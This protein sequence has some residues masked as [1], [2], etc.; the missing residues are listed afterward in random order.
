MDT[1]IWLFLV[2]QAGPAN[3]LTN[4]WLPTILAIVAVGG[5]IWGATRGRDEASSRLYGDAMKMVA[6]L[7]EKVA[8]ERTKRE[9][10]ELQ[11]V[12]AKSERIELERQMIRLIT[13]NEDQ[14]ARIVDLETRLGGR[15]ESD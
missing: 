8:E 14:E 4:V 7:K 9:H 2:A 10:L 1:L 15:R 5:L 12:E 11:L 13:R 6:E 3:P